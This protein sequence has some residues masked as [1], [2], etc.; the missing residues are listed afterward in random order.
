[1]MMIWKRAKIVRTETVIRVVQMRNT[2]LMSKCEK[3]D[4]DK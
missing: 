3:M 2:F 1:M 4:S